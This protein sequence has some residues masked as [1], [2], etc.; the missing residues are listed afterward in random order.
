M[1]LNSIWCN[2]DWSLLL[3]FIVFVN[4]HAMVGVITTNICNQKFIRRIESYDSLNITE[5]VF[6]HEAKISILF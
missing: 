4:P 6:L 5:S 1:T 2:K 3:Q